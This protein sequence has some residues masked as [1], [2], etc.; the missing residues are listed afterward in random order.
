MKLFFC[1]ILILL[2]ATKKCKWNSDFTHY[3]LQDDTNTTTI[4]LSNFRPIVIKAGNFLSTALGGG[5]KV[6]RFRRALT[7]FL[8][9][10]SKSVSD[11]W[12]Q[13]GI[14]IQKIFGLWDFGHPVFGRFVLKLS[15]WNGQTV[16][17]CIYSKWSLPPIGGDSV[18]ISSSSLHSSCSVPQW[19]FTIL[20]DH[21]SK[22]RFDTACL[23]PPGVSCV[24]G[25]EA[26]AVSHLLVVYFVENRLYFYFPFSKEWSFPETLSTL[27][28]I[29]PSFAVSSE[30]T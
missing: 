15:C 3:L 8:V 27:P 23:L 4:R 7:P 5:S 16:L 21:P 18:S 10:V 29:R 24:Y 11:N 20:P 26:V 12:I 19:T 30:L 22:L 2:A 28:S 9:N 17:R 25:A 6:N 13:Q 1:I 14:A